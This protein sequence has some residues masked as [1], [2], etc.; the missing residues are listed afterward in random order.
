VEGPHVKIAGKT[1]KRPELVVFARSHAEESLVSFCKRTNVPSGAM[2]A[3]SGCY[4]GGCTNCFG[5]SAS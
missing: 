5:M 3:D 1:W 2:A 4:S